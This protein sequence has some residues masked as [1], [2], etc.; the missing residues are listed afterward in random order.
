MYSEDIIVWSSISGGIVGV[1]A[2]A[3]TVWQCLARNVSIKETTTLGISALIT[4]LFVGLFIGGWSMKHFPPRDFAI[5]GSVD[6]NITAAADFER[7]AHCL[8]G[9]DND[10]HHP[11]IRA[12]FT[13]YSRKYESR[14]RLTVE[15]E[16]M[17]MLTNEGKFTGL[18]IYS[19]TYN[20]REK[21]RDNKLMPVRVK[22]KDYWVRTSDCVAD[23]RA[24]ESSIMAILGS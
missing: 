12:E 8:A 18:H 15:N 16:T 5:P 13:R 3:L 9:P 1:I 23:R 22:R 6:Q 21:Q 17:G 2:A 10:R 4:P 20:F 7:G 14:Q 24:T 19:I 11:G